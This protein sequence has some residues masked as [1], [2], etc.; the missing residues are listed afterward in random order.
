MKYIS[1]VPKGIRNMSTS[2][3]NLGLDSWTIGVAAAT[4]FI[5]GG[6]VSDDLKDH[7]SVYLQN[8]VIKTFVL[9]AVLFF[10]TRSVVIALLISI[11]LTS[12]RQLQH[13]YCCQSQCLGRRKTDEDAEH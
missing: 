9:F 1:I 7:F 12:L 10:F 2:I 5:A 8:N 3:A 6:I 4:M 11:V 13:H